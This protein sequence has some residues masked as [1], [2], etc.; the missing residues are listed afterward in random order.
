MIDDVGSTAAHRVLEIGE[1]TRLIAGQLVVVGNQKSAVNLACSSRYLEEPVLSALWETQ[2]SLHTLLK[3]LPSHTWHFGRE[4]GGLESTVCGLN[5]TFVRSNVG[6]YGYFS[7]RLWRILHQRVGTGCGVTRLG[8]IKSTW[9]I[10]LP[11]EKAPSSSY[12]ST[13]LPTGGSQHCENYVGP[14]QDPPSLM[15][16]SAF[17]R[18]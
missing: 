11:S 9:K 14:S 7:S 6:V 2:S 8:C 17:L 1:L 18:I 3:T 5:F 4:G 13:C 15:L 12:A 10:V 16:T